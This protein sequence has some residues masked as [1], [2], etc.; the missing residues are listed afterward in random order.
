MSCRLSR[1]R[2]IGR[3]P[4]SRSLVAAR[5]PGRG[6]DRLHRHRV[7]P[8]NRP[9]ASRFRSRTCG[10]DRSAATTPTRSAGV[11]R[12]RSGCRTSDGSGFP[13]RDTRRSAALITVQ[14]IVDY[15]MA[16]NA[17]CDERSR[18]RMSATAP[19]RH[20]RSRPCV[21]RPA[22]PQRVL[23]DPGAGRS[24]IRRIRDSTPS[25]FPSQIAAEIDDGCGLRRCR[26]LVA[27]RP[28][29]RYAGRRGG[30]SPEGLPSADPRADPTGLASRSPP[31]WAATITGR[32]SR[33]ARRRIRAS[34]DFDWRLRRHA[35]RRRR[36]DGA[37][38]VGRR[39]PSRR[40]RHELRVPRSGDRAS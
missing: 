16:R 33:P 9:S 4:K 28:H 2:S 3:S 36:I 19:R 31:G 6:V 13:A 15:S 12:L 22:A 5:R 35:A 11:E 40:D 37:P 20:H 25:T 34:D 7:S 30:R 29:H 8:R 38:S 26:Q 23:A 24:A 17:R 18:D 14:T 21:S 27:T 1:T 39:A 32:C 10:R